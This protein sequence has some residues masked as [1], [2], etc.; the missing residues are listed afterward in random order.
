M[1]SEVFTPAKIRRA[2]FGVTAPRNV[3]YDIS[4]AAFICWRHLSKFIG[5]DKHKFSLKGE[6]IPVT[7]REGP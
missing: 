6:A 3:V 7:G 5:L 4:V 2:V 1:S